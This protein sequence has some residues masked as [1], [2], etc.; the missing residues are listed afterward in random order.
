VHPTFARAFEY[1]RY[2]TSACWPGIDLVTGKVHALVKDR[3]RSREIMEFLK[4]LDAAHPASTAI[5]L[6][7]HNQSAH[8]SKETRAWVAWLNLVE[9]SFSRLKLAHKNRLSLDLPSDVRKPS[10]WRC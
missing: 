2:G 10:W 6:I 8:I 5:K 7:L 4:L 3:H 1:K 9:G